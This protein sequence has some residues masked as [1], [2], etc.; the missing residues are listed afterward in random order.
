MDIERNGFDPDKHSVE[1]SSNAIGV[2]DSFRAEHQIPTNR[3]TLGL[4]SM[5]STA[6]GKPPVI[7]QRLKRAP[8]I[9]RKLARLETSMLARLEDI[10]GCRAVLDTPAEMEAVRARIE[11]NWARDITRRRD[12]VDLS[13]PMGYRALH[14]TVKRYERKVEVQL[15][16]VGQ[17]LW[18][19]A[20][21]AADSR[22]NLTLKD[23]VGP[24]SMLEYFSALGNF[25]YHHE[26]AETTDEIRDRLLTAENAVISDG[27]YTRR[28]A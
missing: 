7:T 18:A 20:I 22:L 21:E 2:L 6:T 16:T 10:G 17:Q 3:V 23:G 27:Y 1:K 19:N 15:R 26:Y 24:D 13:N 11:K 8:R 9:V 12:Y 5:V 28:P 4:R 25:I 14:F